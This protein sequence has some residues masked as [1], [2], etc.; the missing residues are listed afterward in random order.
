[1]NIFQIIK[2]T[3][4]SVK[5]RV[6]V[7]ISIIILLIIIWL[8]SGLFKADA[9]DI[10]G[11]YAAGKFDKVVSQ[12]LV[13]LKTHS[14]DTK[15]LQMVAVASIKTSETTKGLDTK[16]IDN[17]ALMLRSS[18]NK[19]PDAETFRILGNIYFL[20][21][22]YVSAM[23]FYNRSLAM[24]ESTNIGSLLGIG[25]VFMAQ[26]NSNRSK[27]YFERAEQ[28]APEN[29]DVL[30][31]V[32]EYY[33]NTSKPV[34]TEEVARKI[35]VSDTDIYTKSIGHQMLGIALLHTGKYKESKDEFSEALAINPF[36]TD[37]MIG[38]AQAIIKLIVD[39]STKYNSTSEYTN[40]PK[41]L[42]EKVLKYDP[43]NAYALDLLSRIYS[44]RK[45]TVNAKIYADKAR[46]AAGNREISESDRGII[47]NQSATSSRTQINIKSIKVSN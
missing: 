25:R 18:G 36:M 1:M 43:N 23:G 21:K 11:Y 26:N 47:Y 37:S 32:G 44:I 5:K 7:S 28:L 35:L 42:V 40:E 9:K 2:R 13:Y 45:D 31:A 27:F 10:E 39:P 20:K 24:T 34:K 46:V 3:D 12:G 33:L 4:P 16:L 14:E 29:I 17:V 8:F 41:E 15:T 19:N 38:K 22:D 6:I 30:L